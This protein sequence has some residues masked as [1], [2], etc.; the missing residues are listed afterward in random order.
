MIQGRSR[1]LKIN[2]RT[3]DETRL[4]AVRLLKGVSID[5]LDGGTDDQKGYKSLL[6]GASPIVKVF[7]SFREEVDYIA[8]YLKS[9]GA[10]NGALKGVCIV[11]RTNNL[12]TQYK[13]ALNEKGFDVYLIKRSEAEDRTAPGVRL[14]TMHRVKGLEFDRVII[15]GVNDGIIPFEGAE[16]RSS[17]S[18]VKANS[19]ISERA[20]LYVSATRAKKEVLVTAFG[21]HSRFIAGSH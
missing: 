10:E 12:L 4:W 14:A 2:Y 3:T 17:D 8:G 20:L 6:H 7:S 16:L 13:S 15:A 11:A 1:K 18:T 21:K 5:D 9:A 19:E